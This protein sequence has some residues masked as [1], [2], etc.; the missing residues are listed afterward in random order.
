MTSRVNRR[1]RHRQHKQEAEIRGYRKRAEAQEVFLVNLFNS[2]RESRD[3]MLRMRR[4]LERA[5]LFI[6]RLQNRLDIDVCQQ[7]RVDIET[8]VP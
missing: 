1:Q 3:A 5:H 7:I 6:A 4:E 8:M 2:A